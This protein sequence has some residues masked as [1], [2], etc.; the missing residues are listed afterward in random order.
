MGRTASRGVERLAELEGNCIMLT[1]TIALLVAV[2]TPAPAGSAVPG[3]APARLVRADSAHTLFTPNAPDAGRAGQLYRLP[4]GGLG[5]TTGGTSYYQT[6]GMPGGS[7]V[8]VPN[9]NNSFSEIGS[10]GRVGTGT[11]RN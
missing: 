8:A 9:G 2:S 11:M 7:G 3:V 10:G 4:Q 1:T 5:V 6:L